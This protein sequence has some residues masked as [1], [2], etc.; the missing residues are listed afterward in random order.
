[1]PVGKS[2]E[3]RTRVEVKS[4]RHRELHQRGDKLTWWQQRNVNPLR[5]AQIIWQQTRPKAPPDD[6]NAEHR[7]GV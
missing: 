3:T 1:V 6:E 5:L 2:D 4:R 7:L